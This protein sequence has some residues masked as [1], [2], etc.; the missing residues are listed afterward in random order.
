MLT[1]PLTK[2]FINL[3]SLEGIIKV[4]IKKGKKMKNIQNTIKVDNSGFFT[5]IL[6]GAIALI[7]L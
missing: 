1:I 5:I 4:N 7:I 3:S 2:P 6:L